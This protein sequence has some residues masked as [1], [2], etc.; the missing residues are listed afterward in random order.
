MCCPRAL[1][2]LLPSAVRVRIRSRSNKKEAGRAV[3]PCPTVVSLIALAVASYQRCS[4]PPAGS[5]L[6]PGL[7]VKSGAA[8]RQLVF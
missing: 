2:R 7:A 3:A 4:Q 8:I 5:G 6:T 1:A